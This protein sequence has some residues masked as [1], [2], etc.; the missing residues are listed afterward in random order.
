MAEYEYEGPGPH[1]DDEGGITR[2]GDR[3]EF[4]EEPDWGPWRLVPGE[5][6]A[7]EGGQ[8]P[9]PPEASPAALSAA[10]ALNI[11]P[12]PAATSEGM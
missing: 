9:S 10:P 5:P 2:P 6:E 4:E 8:P 1:V 12:A 3:R 7:D 11:T